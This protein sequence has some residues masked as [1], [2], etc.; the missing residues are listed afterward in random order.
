[1]LGR[2]SLFLCLVAFAPSTVRLGAI[3]M[4]AIVFLGVGVARGLMHLGL[5]LQRAVIAGVVVQSLLLFPLISGGSLAK[6]PLAS[7]LLLTGMAAG[8]WVTGPLARWLQGCA[9][10]T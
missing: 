9:P 1:M 6:G 8:A 5:A 2:V 7:M 3:L 10:A 4:V